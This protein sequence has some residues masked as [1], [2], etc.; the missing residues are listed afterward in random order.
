MSVT[1]IPK[2]YRSK[3]NLYETQLAIGTLKRIFEEHLCKA[4]NLKRVSAPLFVRAN[5]GLNDNLNGIERPVAFETKEGGMQ[6]EIVHSLAKW[7]RLALHKYGF[8]A[9]EGLYT[10]M[11]AIRRDEQMDNIHSIYVDQWDWERVITKEERTVAF[12]KQIVSDIVSAICDTYERMRDI[13]P[14]LD[15]DISREVFF[16]TAQQLED[17]YPDLTSKEREDAIVRQHKTVFIMQIG[18]TL[19][20]GQKH[21]GRAPDY[22]DWELNGDILMYNEVLDSA[23]EISSMGIRV[24]SE[25]LARQLKLS[26]CEDRKELMFHKMLLNNELPLS[27]GG[28]IGQ[29]RLCMLL[30]KKAHI[31]EVQVSIWDKDTIEACKEAKVILL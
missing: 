9:G 1:Y 5:S 25:S 26:G 22:D 24:D 15:T 19:K 23:L 2:G 30:L 21:D 12:L 4:I 6:A 31:G 20:S 14:A 17:M 13:F 16:I 27:I 18:K 7:K 3:L 29:S 10:D 28:G 8:P 11:N